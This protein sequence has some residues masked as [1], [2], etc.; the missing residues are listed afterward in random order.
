MNPIECRTNIKKTDVA[1]KDIESLNRR[2][3]GDLLLEDFTEQEIEFIRS[4]ELDWVSYCRNRKIAKDVEYSYER[5]T[6][7]AICWLDKA[8]PVI[9]IDSEFNA[10]TKKIKEYTEKQGRMSFI[11]RHWIDDGRSF[12]TS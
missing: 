9:A 8:N 5:G 10:L 3:L 7:L 12:L 11:Y 2:E 1:Q 4:G 6:L